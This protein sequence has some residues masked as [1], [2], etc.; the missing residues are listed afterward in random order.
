MYL[1]LDLLL[2]FGLA[3]LVFI[4]LLLLDGGVRMVS[5]CYDCVDWI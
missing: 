3:T 2:V 5:G 1:I 4:L